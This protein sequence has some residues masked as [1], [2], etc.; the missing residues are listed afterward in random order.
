MFSSIRKQFLRRAIAALVAVA[1][2]AG[3]AQAATVNFDG[4]KTDPYLESGFSFT[5]ARL[6][7]GNCLSGQCLALNDNETTGMTLVSPPGPFTLAS[8]Y[9]KLL[10]NG[11]GNTLTISGSN[12][13]A[14]SFSV[15]T[16]AKNTYHQALFT[17]EFQDVTSI[18]FSTTEG[19]NVRIDDVG[20]TPAPIP[21]PGA[22]LLLI[23]GLG[24]L[25]AVSRRKR[26]AA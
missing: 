8:L 5:P 13:T 26:A 21:L 22:S 24:A 17:T 23:G 20:A 1:G 9:F 4:A 11:T 19:G 15:P 16:Y 10:G 25:G 14:L 7:S 6:V 2:C 12:G 18:I 3:A